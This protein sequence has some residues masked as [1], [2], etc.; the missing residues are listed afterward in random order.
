[1][2][3][4]DRL[5]QDG[6]RALMGERARGWWLLGALA[7]AAVAS[8]LFMKSV[9]VAP[10]AGDD[11]MWYPRMAALDSWSVG[12]ALG[13]LPG[14][15][16][17]RTEDGRVNI[18]TPLERR[19]AGRLV[20]DM[21]VGT[22][23]PTYVVNGVLKMLLALAAALSL[24]ALLK[25][26]RRRRTDGELVRL[27]GRTIVLCSLVGG[28]LFAIGSQ[29]PFHQVNGR[30]GWVNYPTHTYGAVVSILGVTAL[31][32]WLTRLYAEGRY[33]FPIVLVLV[34]LAVATTL[35]YELVFPAAPLSLIAL[36]LTPVAPT[37]LAAAGRRAKWM[38]GVSYVG[39]FMTFLVAQ[40]VYLWQVC[41]DGCY[42]GVEPRLS[43]DIAVTF[44]HNVVSSVPGTTATRVADFVESLGISSNG[45]YTPTPLSLVLGVSMTLVLLVAWWTTRT[46]TPPTYRDAN[47]PTEDGIARGSDEGKLLALGAVL[48]LLGA[49]GAAGVMSLSVKAQTT[50]E[51]GLPYRHTVVTWAGIAWALGMGALALRH[52]SPRA[53]VVTWVGVS[54]AVGLAAACLLPANERSLAADRLD[55][56]ATEAAFAALVNGDLSDAANTHRCRLVPQIVEERKST[57]K[58]FDEA[59][60]RYW[61][62]EFCR[63]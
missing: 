63:R 15:W 8:A 48:C 14:W 27:S 43:T 13:E 1:M 25:S 39:V 18:L 42:S 60:R 57:A 31:V 34:L 51:L 9:F 56:H 52:R 33:R 12:D 3:S 10:V 62:Q 19:T 5:A 36:L 59:F 47:P 23:T 44:W 58:A 46:A 4:S 30:N 54:V 22:G 16:E 17:S 53:A 26:L 7:L 20:V 24:P 21:S 29:P 40:R 28:V 37:R 35:R 38:T 45:M 41:K 61:G 55:T 32:L 50:P 2:G 11:R 49:L 6:T